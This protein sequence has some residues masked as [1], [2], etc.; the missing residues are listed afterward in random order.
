[1]GPGARGALAAAAAA[2]TLA[3]SALAAPAD[4]TFVPGKSLGGA[5]LGMTPAQVALVWGRTHGVCRSC[6]RTTWYFNAKPFQPQG[7]AAS[8]DGGRAVALWTVWQPD[9]WRTREGLALGDAVARI[10]ETY[11]ALERNVCGGYEA[12]VR[13]RGK[14][15]S[16]F[17]VVDS[18]L[19]GFGLMSPGLS[20]C[21]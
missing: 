14:A 8:F 1:V 11:G 18:K 15:Q 16:V 3:T 5:R 19:W 17:Y 4:T 12:L 7:V 6:A 9:G 20:P 13:R 10:T 21:L 2:L